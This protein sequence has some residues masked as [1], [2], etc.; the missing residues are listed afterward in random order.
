MRADR[1]I[2]ER[3]KIL[4]RSQ[5]K[6]RNAVIL[7]NGKAGKLSHVLK[8]GDRLEISFDDVAP[9]WLEPED[10]PLSILYEDE[11][12]IVIDKPQGLVVHPA[13]GNPTGTL[14]NALLH[15][16]GKGFLGAGESSGVRPGI[17]HRLDKDTSG[18]IVAAKSPEAQEFLSSQFRERQTTKAY[19]AIVK[20]APEETRGTVK[21]WLTRDPRQRKRFAVSAGHGKYAVTGYRVIRRYGDYSLML[22]HPKTGRTHQLRVHL[23]WLGCPILGDPIYSKP[24]RLFPG[25]TL[26]L[27]AYRLRITLPGHAERSTFTA[28]LP[29]RFE[30]ILAELE[31]SFPTR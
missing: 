15:H 3:L 23:Q 19:L 30:A 20:G 29:S 27:H 16:V 6:A 5:L 17:V 31:A 10:I 1:Y 7:V 9:T 14:V 18:V 11:N 22:L 21:T 8:T 13:A 12:A 4:T 2:A 24:D 25:A 28:P 26:M